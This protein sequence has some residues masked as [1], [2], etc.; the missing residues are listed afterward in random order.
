M[1]NNVSSDV[2]A[3]NQNQY[4]QNVRQKNEIDPN[5]EHEESESRQREQNIVKEKED[6]EI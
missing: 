1:L 4:Y 3:Q 5:T 2:L 6:Q